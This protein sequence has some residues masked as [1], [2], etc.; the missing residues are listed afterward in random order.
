MDELQFGFKKGR[1]CQDAINTLRAI[2]SSTNTNQLNCYVVCTAQIFLGKHFLSITDTA[3]IYSRILI[4]RSSNSVNSKSHLYWTD[5][6]VPSRQPRVI[7]YTNCGQVFWTWLYRAQTNQCTDSIGRLLYA[8]LGYSEYAR[9]PCHSKQHWLY[10]S[11]H[12]KVK[13]SAKWL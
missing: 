13:S 9:Q 4:Y 12:I 3:K 10:T 1:G 5:V 6:S 11:L 7:K 8:C 2:V